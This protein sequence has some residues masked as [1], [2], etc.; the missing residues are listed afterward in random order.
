M[1]LSRSYYTEVHLRQSPGA[2]LL[3]TD[4]IP[5]TARKSRGKAV[6]AAQL[7]YNTAPRYKR[8]VARLRLTDEVHRKLAQEI[9]EARA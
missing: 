7:R 8:T 4:P 5:G 6:D 2:P 1:T 3:L 9:K